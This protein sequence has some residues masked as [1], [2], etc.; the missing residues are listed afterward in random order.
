[1]KEMLG[2]RPPASALKNS[3]APPMVNAVVSPASSAIDNRL[4]YS[5]DG[6]SELRFD[7]T[8]SFSLQDYSLM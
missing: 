6:T 1:M 5:C 7:I 8:W 4:N 3:S 2:P